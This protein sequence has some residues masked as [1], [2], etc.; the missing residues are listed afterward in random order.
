MGCQFTIGRDWTNPINGDKSWK[1][2]EAGRKYWAEYFDNTV[3]AQLR[4]LVT[5]YGE[6]SIL[7][8]DSPV[9]S[10]KTVADRLVATVHKY[11]PN[12]VVNVTV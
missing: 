2:S 8:F 7:W 4:E 1:G 5:N 12:C 10:D 11:Q 6:I 9:G 3:L